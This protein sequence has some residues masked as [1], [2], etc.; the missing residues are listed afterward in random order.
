[1]ADRTRIVLVERLGRLQ[2]AHFEIRR[3]PMPVPAP[4]A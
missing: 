3:A 4:Q 1:M 2:D